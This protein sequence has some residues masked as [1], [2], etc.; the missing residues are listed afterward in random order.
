MAMT[1]A[2][3]NV[4]PWVKDAAYFIGPKFGITLIYGVAAGQFD[5]PKGLA[6]DFMISNIKNGHAVGDQ[7]ATYVVAN[8][9]A[10]NI[11]YVI[12]NR[13][14]IYPADSRGWHAY[15]GVSP[16][17]DHVHTSY[18]AVP[19][20]NSLPSAGATPGDVVPVGNPIT[21][22]EAKVSQI[23]GVLDRVNNVFGWML[24]RGNQRRVGLY[25]FGLLFIFLGLFEFNKVAA[26]VMEAATKAV[27]GAVSGG[28]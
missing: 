22:T 16:H 14:I 1:Y 7:L 23:Y 9:Q 26:P 20:S 6:L 3:G 24:D 10:L 15:T 17:T 5:H 27:K 12:W 18:K 4:K 2:L 28:K 21:D 8:Y 13:R 11:T 19:T 25:A